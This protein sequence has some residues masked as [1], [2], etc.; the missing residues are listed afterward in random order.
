MIDPTFYNIRRE[1]RNELCAEAFRWDDLKRWR[2]LDQFK[3]TP[4]RT[5]GMRYWGSVYEEQLKDLCIVNPSTG[6]MSSPE[7]SVYILP[8]EKILE[9]NTIAK[10]KGFLFTPAHYLEPIGV[11]VFRQ[12]ASDPNDF[13][14]SSVY[15]NPGWKYEAS[16]GAVSVE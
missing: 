16:T 7:S 9:N 2:A 8:Y 11:A 4:Y 6:N 1:R 13:T 14:S 15:Q 3:T 5:E 10:Q 12:T